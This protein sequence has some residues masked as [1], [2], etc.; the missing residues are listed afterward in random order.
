MTNPRKALDVLG[1]FEEVLHNHGPDEKA[2]REA[3]KAL[4]EDV[5][6]YVIGEDYPEDSALNVANLASG[7]RNDEHEIQRK[8]AAKY[9][10]QLEP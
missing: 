10:G 6:K 9:F 7:Q 1:E 3:Q 4:C 2:L 5:C 8:R